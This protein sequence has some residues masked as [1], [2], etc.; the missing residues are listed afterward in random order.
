MLFEN[1][2]KSLESLR[3]W[4]EHEVEEIEIDKGVKTKLFSIFLA[5]IFLSVTVVIW[6]AKK[7]NLVICPFNF[8]KKLLS[9]LWDHA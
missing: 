1:F 4:G 6:F 7:A 2:R 5:L 3:I 8:V 9:M